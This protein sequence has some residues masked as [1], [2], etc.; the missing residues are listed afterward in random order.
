MSNNKKSVAIVSGG[1]DSITMLY[2]YED[3]ISLVLS[4]D[5]G[6]M[7]NKY[8][9]PFAV[10]HCRKLNIKH[11]IIDI[12]FIGE[13]FKSF[14]FSSKE[15]ADIVPFRNGIMLAIACGYAD[16]YGLEQ[17]M[18]ACNYEDSQVFPDCTYEFIRNYSIGLEK[19]TKN[20]IKIGN[21]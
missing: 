20:K 1:I 12:A 13:T 10:E 7:L 2:E 15:S 14:L 6:A 4:F 21:L 19:G 3:D 9:I 16:N 8:E 5:Y 18:I 11:S 17:V